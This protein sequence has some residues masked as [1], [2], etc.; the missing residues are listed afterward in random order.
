[1]KIETPLFLLY[2]LSFKT[3][4]K[5]DQIIQ[6]PLFQRAQR[7]IIK[8]W[9]FTFLPPSYTVQCGKTRQ[10]KLIFR[11]CFLIGLKV[12]IFEISNYSAPSSRNR[13]KTWETRGRRR[14]KKKPQFRHL[15]PS[16]DSDSTP[17]ITVRRLLFCLAMQ[18]IVFFPS[19]F[20][21]DYSAIRL[22]LE[23]DSKQ[24][25]IILSARNLGRKKKI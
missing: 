21:Q 16:F 19:F 5:I 17:I 8:N 4:S 10:R 24:P 23:R 7:P 20:L 15:F 3:R 25:I 9:V 18:E 12:K 13:R 1:M 2:L 14:R 6:F 22:L 11:T